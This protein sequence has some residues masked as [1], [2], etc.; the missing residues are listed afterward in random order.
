MPGRAL[1]LTHDAHLSSVVQEI[2]REVAI[3][4]QSCET[5]DSARKTIAGSTF[6]AVMVDCDDVQGGTA[7]L[8]DVRR[9]WT[10]KNAAV[11]AVLDGAT[12]P[13]D[14]SD[15]GADSIVSKPVPVD[16]L[17]H[18]LLKVC[19]ILRKREHERVTLTVRVWVTAGAIFERQAESLNISEGGIGLCFEEAN[20]EDELLS[21]KFEL[22]GCK[23]PFLVRGEIV[24][25]DP[26]GRMGVR[27]VGM[28]A[29][30]TEELGRWLALRRAGA[31]EV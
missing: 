30:A 26:T 14:A 22:P 15:M 7:F 2:T 19:G 9:A 21:L 13:A 6:D 31:G 20:L 5:V 16:R 25:A 11:V 17:R 28:P 3:A 18:I 8:R 1:L 10:T 29:P 27:F 12:A 4:L 23:H 24:W